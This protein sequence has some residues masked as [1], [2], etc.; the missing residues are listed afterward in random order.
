MSNM[1]EYIAPAYVMFSVVIFY[2]YFAE[3]FI[4]L[5]MLDNKDFDSLVYL[6]CKPNDFSSCS[7]KKCP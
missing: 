6:S 7:C 5:A 4:L 2:G 3:S 1:P